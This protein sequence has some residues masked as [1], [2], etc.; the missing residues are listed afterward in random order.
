M[1][2]NLNK[3]VSCPAWKRKRWDSG[4]GLNS[5]YLEK[6]GRS[7][8]LL[9]SPNTWRKFLLKPR[10]KPFLSVP[11]RKAGPRTA[12]DRDT[13]KLVLSFAYFTIVL[14]A[15]AYG[16]GRR[17]LNWRV[18]WSHGWITLELKFTDGINAETKF[19]VC[20]SILG[21]KDNLHIPIECFPVWF[22]PMLAPLNSLCLRGIMSCVLLCPERTLIILIFTMKMNIKRS[23]VLLW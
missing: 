10:P 1:L 23:T 2:K 14:V 13:H 18:V 15:M 7:Q 21:Q 12:S 8:Y 9:S 3:N 11:W 6:T 4:G 5:L 20:V 22:M 19:L 16:L 17:T